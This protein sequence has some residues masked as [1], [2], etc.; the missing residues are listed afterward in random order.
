[1]SEDRMLQEAIKAIDKGQLSRARD[2][3]T[4]LLRQD[5][6]NVAYW[7]YM[8][9]VV[10][11]SKE[12][13][14][15]L[16]NALKYD[17]GNQT[18]VQ[19]LVMLGAMKPDSSTTPVRP[20]DERQRE[21]PKIAGITSA[22]S[23]A[24]KK[25][26][27]SPVQIGS[28]ALFGMVSLALI[29][30][31]IFGNP[32]YSGVP[33]VYNTIPPLLTSGPTPTYLPTNTPQGGIVEN[34]G[35]PTPLVLQLDAT[36]TPTPRYVDTPHPVVAAYDSGM[37]NLDTGDYAEAIEFLGQA[38]TAEPGSVDILYYIGLAYLKDGN[39]DNARSFFD[40]ALQI[41]NT[42]APAY[43]GKA[44][45]FR[46]MSPDL[47]VTEQ[48]YK[49]T[50]YDSEYIEAWLAWADYRIFQGV[51]EEALENIDTAF[52]LDPENAE[53]YQLLAKVYIAQNL[54][55][56]AL[57]A[58]QEAFNRDLLSPENYRLLG[59]ALILNDRY[60]EAIPLIETYLQHENED[61]FGW[62]L[63]GRA[64][65]GI[66]NPEGAIEIFRST[67]AE[68]KNIYEMSYYWGLALIDV[69]D[70]A[71]AA[72]RLLVPIQRTPRWF[73]PY[74]AQAEAY[75]LNGQFNLAKEALEAGASRATS[76]EQKAMLY[77][78]RGVIYTEL[79]YPGI[80]KDNWEKLLE[81]PPSAVPTEWWSAAEQALGTSSP[82]ATEA[83]PTPTR[84]PSPTP[85]P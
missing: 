84:V 69:G 13:T 68:R 74:A 78:W 34:I 49:A 30:L 60:N 32:F 47:D 23:A 85:S 17:P 39:Y 10:E 35:G 76:D 11:T 27:L 3:L 14:F 5:Q 16:E 1:M 42:F 43:L 37:I 25:S 66:G 9:A 53:A 72:E 65:Q 70:Y 19:G 8:S 71:T 62:Y 61:Y 45:A 15:C 31:G 56:E 51:Y 79:T 83:A 24:G 7:L 80:A 40:K 82:Q 28:L 75:Y 20:V 58:S 46:G 22:A 12:R 63:F 52:S 73:E 44:L 59:H 50:S 26:R 6:S 4:R 41:D 21:L 54:P 57:E 64:Q 29:L 2:L 36:Y 48:L 77:Y 81:L 38:A 18:A 55:E 67:Y 33:V